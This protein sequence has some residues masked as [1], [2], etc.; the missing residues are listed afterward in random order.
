MEATT[1]KSDALALAEK[2]MLDYFNTHDPKFIAEDG[3]FHNMN[4]GESYRGRAEVGG[5]LH[6]FYH[7][8]FDARAEVD[9]Y[10]ITEDKAMV[11]GR[12]VGKHIG[13]MGPIKA[14]GKDVNFP[15][16]VTYRLRDGLIKEARIYAAND[17]LMQQLG[18]NQQ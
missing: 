18:L 8:L 7:V 16:C 13:D 12:I 5:M 1:I 14:T 2:N 6:F 10:I 9:N 3:V 15:I 11:E 4:T 17:V